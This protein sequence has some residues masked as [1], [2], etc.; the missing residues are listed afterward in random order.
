MVHCS[1]LLIKWKDMCCS[2]RGLPWCLQVLRLRGSEGRVSSVLERLLCG[3]CKGVKS[4]QDAPV[5]AIL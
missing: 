1:S 5:C 2:A 4:R 3:A